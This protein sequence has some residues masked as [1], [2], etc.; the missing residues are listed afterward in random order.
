MAKNIAFYD[1]DPPSMKFYNRT[2]IS[3]HTP[4]CWILS[5]S[6]AHSTLK[7]L[8]KIFQKCS[9]LFCILEC[10]IFF[11]YPSKAELSWGVHFLQDTGTLGHRKVFA[12]PY[13]FSFSIFQYS[14]SFS[15]SVTIRPINF[16]S[17]FS[18]SF[19]PVLEKKEDSFINNADLYIQRKGDF[20]SW[21]IFSFSKRSMYNLLL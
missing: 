3:N 15:E 6:V 18:D 9:S 19:F 4:K 13:W 11:F 2:D 1:Y 20:L 21:K 7:S 10:I 12:L 5:L 8:T 14:F 17:V 16:Q